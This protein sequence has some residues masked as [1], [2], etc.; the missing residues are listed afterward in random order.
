[1]A[2]TSGVGSVVAVGVGLEVA[3]FEEDGWQAVSTDKQAHATQIDLKRDDR[4]SIFL[5]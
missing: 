1:M 2:A 3:T 5:P 4:I